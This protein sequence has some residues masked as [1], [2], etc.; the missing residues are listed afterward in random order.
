[1][2]RPSSGS[3]LLPMMSKFGI[4]PAGTFVLPGRPLWQP[5]SSWIPSTKLYFSLC[6]PDCGARTPSSCCCT[7]CLYT[8]LWVTLLSASKAFMHCWRPMDSPRVHTLAISLSREERVFGWD[9]WTVAKDKL[10]YA[11]FQ[12]EQ[13]IKVEGRKLLLEAPEIFCSVVVSLVIK[14]RDGGEGVPGRE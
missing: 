10:A 4:S 2:G 14:T 5:L 8:G 9:R 7:L 12:L 11:Q 13:F 6:P 3:L 1:M